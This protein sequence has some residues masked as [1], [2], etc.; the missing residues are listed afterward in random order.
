MWWRKQQSKPKPDPKPE[1]TI[2]RAEQ[3]AVATA[4]AIAAAI[5][6]SMAVIQFDVDGTIRDAND[7]FLAVTGYR[8]DEVVGRHHRMFVEPTYAASDEYRRFWQRL[9]AGE[10]QTA[11]FQRVGKGGKQVWIQASYAPI[12]AADGSVA[13]VVKVASDITAQKLRGLYQEAIVQAVDRTHAMIEFEP[14]GTI[15]TA[16]PA[17]LQTTGFALGEIVG[18]HHRIFMPEGKAAQPDYQQLWRDLAAGKPRQGDFERRRKDGSPLFIHAT[19][20]PIADERGRVVRV[21]K[22]ATDITEEVLARRSTE[23]AQSIARSITELAQSSAEINQRVADTASRSTRLAQSSGEAK[24]LVADLDN[25]SDEINHIVD[26]I[27]ELADQT[28][29][30]ALNATIEAARAGEAGRG[31]HVVATEVKQL[32]T[33]TNVALGNIR[34]QIDGIQDRIDSV[35]GAIDGIAANSTQVGDNSTS[36]AAAVGQQTTILEGLRDNAQILLRARQDS[37][38]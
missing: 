19:Y 16:N 34:K 36:V 17:F 35:A 12:R 20:T 13:G 29:L 25:S 11:E 7:A 38:A 22:F 2:D 21:V 23:V 1:P 32:A 14:N 27:R 24:R 15:L 6:A 18:K 31:F 26:C 9:G 3:S 10:A 30:L 4:I 28:T 8:R 33:A 5:D 37:I